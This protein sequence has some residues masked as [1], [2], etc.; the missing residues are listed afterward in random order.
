[1][2]DTSSDEAVSQFLAITGSSDP[3]SAKS[4]L[5]MSGG[6]VQTAIGLFLEHSGP[7][8]TSGPSSSS[9]GSSGGAGFGAAPDVRAPDQTQTMR[10]MD[11]GMG[12]GG[13]GMGGRMGG[14]GGLPYHHPAAAAFMNRGM[15]GMLGGDDEEIDLMAAAWGSLDPTGLGSGASAINS[16]GGAAS[17][18]PTGNFR[19]QINQTVAQGSQGTSINDNIASGT[20][21]VN[22]SV[23]DVTS[24]Y[25]DSN[26]NTA[27]AGGIGNALATT[28]HGRATSLTDMFSPPSHLLHTG[29]GFMG[30]RNVAKES[31][32]WL[33]VN[34]QNEDDFAC[35]ALNRDVW[36]DELV[37]NLIREGFTF[38][39]IMSNCSEGTTYRQRYKAFAYPHVA[40]IDPRT[41]RLLWKKEGWTM[42][43]PLTPEQFVQAASDFCSR[44]S[45]DKEP[46]APRMEN[47]SSGVGGGGGSSITMPPKREMSEEEQ[48]QAAIRASMNDGMNQ[49]GSYDDD[50]DSYII[51][52]DDDDE[53]MGEGDVED[54]KPAAAVESA[55]EESR[56]PTFE[57]EIVT[58][59]V[60]DEPGAG[61]QNV[62]RIMLRMPDGK[63]LVRKFIEQDSVKMIYAFV[64]QSNEEAKGGKPFEL[65]AGFPPKDLFPSVDVSI[66][67]MGLSGDTITVRWKD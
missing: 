54:S 26:T 17:S 6:D 22:E 14:H 62:A 41:G 66:S 24:M 8:S 49:Q 57:E 50:D 35:H 23:E 15:N 67:S 44:H 16:L 2:D 30:A 40:I 37:E 47:H 31:K 33:L 11:D 28:P 19:D 51:E 32:R 58:I 60:S 5:E 55:E 12:S 46:M 38:L 39:Q 1:M 27:P 18:R 52:D 36:R 59:I 21:D 4:Y 34:L 25:A 61:T 53:D 42:Q 65:K 10:L 43:N 48:L 56:P 9:G 7:S 20:N 13:L 45:F 64:A 63:R 29:G 3:S